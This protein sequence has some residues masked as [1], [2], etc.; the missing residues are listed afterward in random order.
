MTKKLTS[1][2]VLSQEEN[3]ATYQIIKEI[4]ANCGYDFIYDNATLSILSNE[5]DFILIFELTK[6]IADKIKGLNLCL[7]IIVDTGLQKKDYLNPSIRSLVKN[8][9]YFIMNLDEKDSINILKEDIE[10]LIFTYGLN[11]KATLT[12]SSLVF[13]CDIRSNIC[14]QRECTTIKGNRIEPMEFPITINLIGRSNFY[15]SLAAI[16]FGIIYG[17][18][19]EKIKSS[20]QNI[21]TTFKRL[22]K[23]CHKDWVIVLDNYCK[24]SS[25]Y[26][27]VFEEIQCVKYNNIYLIKEIDEDEEFY[28]TRSHL[29]V[30]FDWQPIVNIK[31][32]FLYMEKNNNLLKNSIESLF[33]NQPLNYSF[34]LDL[35]QCISLALHSLRE[36]DI[37]LI[38]GKKAINNAKE[39][40]CQLN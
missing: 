19:I 30:I 31:K 3:N 28:E 35:Q 20:L 18:S 21:E 22:E 38:L 7:D 17:I 15:N 1:I 14:L 25:D 16:A 37:L 11:N 26:N 6:K 23:I 39:I 40:I 5:D 13:D 27:F 12:A 10:S 4:L 36:G 8:S 2:G 29:K 33:N 24:Y 34:H 9:K 32:I